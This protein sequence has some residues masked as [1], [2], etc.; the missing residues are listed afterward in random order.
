LPEPDRSHAAIAL[1]HGQ[2]LWLLDAGEGVCSALLRCQLN[3]EKVRA[4]YITHLHPD[5]CVGVFM[6]L[7]YLHVRTFTGELKIYLPGGAIDVFQQFLNQLYLVPG[8]IHP[9][10]TLWPL[11]NRHRLTTGITLETFPTKHL[12]RWDASK[13][14][15]LETRSF[16]F[17]VASRDRSFFYSG[18]IK[19]VSDLEPHIKSRELLILEAA[20]IEFEA[21]IKLARKFHLERMLLTHALPAHREQLKEL[22]QMGAQIGLEIQFAFDGMKITV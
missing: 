17:R 13:L 11:E 22:Q 7:Q 14:P 1:S 16:A 3:P 19:E 10:Y 21:V 15:D 9:G 2:D 12:E 6:L 20:H 5:H 8:E 4:I 18:D